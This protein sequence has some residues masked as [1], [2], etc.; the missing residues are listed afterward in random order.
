MVKQTTQDREASSIIWNNL[1]EMVRIKVREF[2]QSLL[3]ADQ[4]KKRWNG[5]GSGW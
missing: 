4:P 5:T 2:I 1:E 3:E